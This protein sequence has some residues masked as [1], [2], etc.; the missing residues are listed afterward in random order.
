MDVE[1]RWNSVIFMAA[2]MIKLRPYLVV[3]SEEYDVKRNLRNASIHLPTEEQWASAEH[4]V[5]YLTPFVDEIEQWSGQKYV[6]MSSV[7]PT[8]FGYLDLLAPKPED[9]TFV[10]QQKQQI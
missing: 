2:R 9:T 7:Y 8:I 4:V 1:T 5:E 3:A 10:E 6:T